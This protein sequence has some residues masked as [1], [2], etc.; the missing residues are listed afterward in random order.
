MK[1]KNLNRQQKNQL[2]IKFLSEIIHGGTGISPY[3]R[4]NAYK[5]VTDQ[6]IKDEYGEINFTKNYFTN[7][8]KI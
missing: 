1:F 8:R 5:Y 7:L 6:E 4:D 2:K 3:E